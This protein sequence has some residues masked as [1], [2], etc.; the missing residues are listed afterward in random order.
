MKFLPRQ[1]IPKTLTE[2]IT[3]NSQGMINSQSISRYFP[4]ELSQEIRKEF[5]KKLPQ[6][7]QNK[8]L[9]KFSKPLSHFCCK[10]FTGTQMMNMIRHFR[11]FK[12]LLAWR[13]NAPGLH[14]QTYFRPC[15]QD[16]LSSLRLLVGF[17]VRLTTLMR[18]YC[19]LSTL[20]FMVQVLSN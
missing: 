3:S 8:F 15:W 12:P 9:K 4:K 5:P 7:F 14:N 17:W 6:T 11:C 13:T 10:F 18:P 20:I 2:K 16:T 1:A 19:E